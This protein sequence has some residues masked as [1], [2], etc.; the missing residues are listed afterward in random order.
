[1]HPGIERISGG[2]LI[3]SDCGIGEWLAATVPVIR[4]RRRIALLVCAMK[5]A[6]AAIAQQAPITSSGQY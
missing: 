1:M 3:E 6:T 5:V 2:S 4:K